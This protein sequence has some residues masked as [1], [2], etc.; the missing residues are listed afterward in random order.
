[1]PQLRRNRPGTASASTVE[2]KLRKVIPV[3]PSTEP[4]KSQLMEDL[5]SMGCQGLATKPWGFKEEYLLRELLEK[6]SN[7]F[8][9]T[10]RAV[11]SL[12]KEELWRT[13]YGFRSGGLGMASRKDEFV[14]GKFRGAVNPK[15]GYA[16]ED[17]VDDRHRRLLSFLVPILHPEKPTRMT[18]T[19]A[20]TIF[21]ALSRDRKVD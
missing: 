12:W 2:V 18:I 4:E 21:G 3:I 14:R 8:D 9:G 20:N 13:V 17:C 19:L 1:M 7:E 10:L 15:D 11:P 16:I 5:T 6:P